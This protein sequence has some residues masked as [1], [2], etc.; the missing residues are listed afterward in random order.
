MLVKFL[1]LLDIIAGF[2]I[3]ILKFGF[4]QEVGLIFALYLALKGLIFIKDISSVIDI[5]TAVFLFLAAINF[6]FSFTWIFSI[7]LFQKGIFSLISY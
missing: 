6:Y 7:W 4:F 5:I 2:I 3:L 1:G